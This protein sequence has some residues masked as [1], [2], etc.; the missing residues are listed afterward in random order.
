[1]GGIYLNFAHITD[2]GK[3]RDNNEDCYYVDENKGLF[4]VADGMGGHN[5]GEI[6]SRYAIK[7]FCAHFYSLID[8]DDNE[9]HIESYI[10]R[11]VRFANSKLYEIS[12][13]IKSLDGMG[14]TLTILYLYK[15]KAYIGNVGD[16]R[17][18]FVNDVLNQITTDHSLVEELLK[19]G[20]ITEEEARNHPQR[21]IIT[22][23]VGS[24]SGVE[25]QLIS[26]PYEGEKVLLATD[27]LTNLVEDFEI[28]DLITSNSL[29]ESCGKLVNLANDRGGNDNITV[30]IFEDFRF[31]GG[32]R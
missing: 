28:Y 17:V 7:F 10:D 1:L 25:I 20:E 29:E 11:S 23:A 21:N 16:S 31:V 14:T 24:D 13:D 15:G 32:N 27:G 19:K 6:A 9:D 26:M 18:Y 3:V 8:E 22:Q 4:I 30:V 12:K 5:A 2:V